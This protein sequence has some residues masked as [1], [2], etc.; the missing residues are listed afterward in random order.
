M[1]TKPGQ[2]SLNLKPWGFYPG[3]TGNHA[4]RLLQAR[5]YDHIFPFLMQLLFDNENKPADQR[6]LT[7]TIT[8]HFTSITMWIR[9]MFSINGALHAPRVEKDCNAFMQHVY[10][11][12]FFVF[13]FF[14]TLF[15]FLF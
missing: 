2:F 7:V 15:F 8:Q 4:D 11:W 6:L 12:Y 1:M 13:T 10:K 3:E 5:Y 9:R 14:Y